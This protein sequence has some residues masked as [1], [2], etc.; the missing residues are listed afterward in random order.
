MHYG[1]QGGGSAWSSISSYLTSPIFIALISGC[2]GSF[3]L[4]GMDNPVWDMVLTILSIISASMVVFVAL[5]VAL[6]LRWIPLR[7]FGVLAFAT[8]FLTLILRP[9]IALVISDQ[10][11]LNTV[12]T[13]ILVLET[14]MPSSMV[15]AVLADRYGCDGEL[16]SLLVIATYIFSLVTIPLIMVLAP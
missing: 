13:D 2:I 6:M 14:A 15:A 4:A 10:I 9:L 16:G 5:G 11:N 7:T 12:I 3:F 8:V 1:G